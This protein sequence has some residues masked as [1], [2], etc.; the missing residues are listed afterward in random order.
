M[1]E[2]AIAPHVDHD[3]AVETLAE[4]D[5]HLA[6]KGHR[7]RIV[8]IDVED[9]RLHTLGHIAW[10][11]R[12][13]RELR[14]GGKADLIVD[15]EVDTA[16]GVVPTDAGETEAFPDDALS[17]KGGIAVEQHRQHLFMLAQIVADRLVC[18]DLSKHHRIHRLKVR[19]VGNQR[20]MDFDA[21]KFTVGR[22]A[23]VI[24]H[25]TRTADIFGVGRAARK[26]VEDDAIGFG[27]HI[28]EHV[29]AAAMRHAIDDFAH[30]QMAAIFDDGF[31]RRDHRFAAIKAEALGADIFFGEEFLILLGL[32][33]LGED[34]LLAFRSEGN[35]GV[36]AFHPLLQE[37]ALL[38]IGDMHIFKANGSAI[39][40]T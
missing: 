37:T 1:A 22:G 33:H 17:S 16:T 3:V 38:D 40:C 10:I 25:I 31:E 23:E 30:A 13:A 15:D 34:G 21:V 11:G 14:A 20:H 28:G 19:R 9:R 29:E 32:D 39:I 4:L 12:G 27:H 24:F 36:A 26:F 7:L 18:T 5:C 6:G 35:R 8:A 2:A